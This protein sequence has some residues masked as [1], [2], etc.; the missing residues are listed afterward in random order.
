MYSEEF[1]K[2]LLKYQNN[3]F[4]ETKKLE[5]SEKFFKFMQSLKNKYATVPI[6]TK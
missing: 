5:R 1:V 2:Y 3:D 4:K 6:Q